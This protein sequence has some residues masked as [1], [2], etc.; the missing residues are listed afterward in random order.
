MAE[1]LSSVLGRAVRYERTPIEAYKTRLVSR[2]MSEAFAQ[3]LADMMTA[4]NEGIDNTS[5]LAVAADTPTTFRQWSE[6]ILK[7]AVAGWRCTATS[8]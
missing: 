6:T 1:V 4:K 7:P 3:G 2:G 5:S 8:S